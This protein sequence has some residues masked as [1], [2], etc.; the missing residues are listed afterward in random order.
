MSLFLFRPLNAIGWL[1]NVSSKLKLIGVRGY[2][3]IYSHLPCCCWCSLCFYPDIVLKLV[4]DPVVWQ[5]LFIF[6]S[7]FWIPGLYMSLTPTLTLAVTPRYM[8]IK[9]TKCSQFWPRGPGTTCLRI[10]TQLHLWPLFVLSLK[11]IFWR[12][13]S[14]YPFSSFIVF[15]VGKTCCN[16]SKA[17][18]IFTVKIRWSSINHYVR[19]PFMLKN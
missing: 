14:R 6:F 2:S 9:R 11:H 4:K 13:L 3:D 15:F 1:L 17:D 7:L 5:F 8:L 18:Y 19:I 16:W 12:A 10:L